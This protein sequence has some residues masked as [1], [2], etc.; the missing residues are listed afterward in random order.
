MAFGDRRQGAGERSNGSVMASLSTSP[1][2]LGSEARPGRRPT[3]RDVAALAGVSFKTVS[4]VVNDE[5]GVSPAVA[6]RVREAADTL[7]YR[8]NAAATALRR[9]DGRT[10]TL[11]VLLE[12]SGNPFFAAPRR[13]ARSRGGPGPPR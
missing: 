11:G 13:G 8:P 7:G 9:A 1:G 5:P 4:R 2:P 3:L 10:A 6:A 12:D